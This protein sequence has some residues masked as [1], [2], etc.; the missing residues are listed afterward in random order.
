MGQGRPVTHARLRKG[1]TANVA[2]GGFV[3]PVAVLRLSDGGQRPEY[4]SRFGDEGA[5]RFAARAVPVSVAGVHDF[6]IGLPASRGGVV[7]DRAGR[8]VPVQKLADVA[9]G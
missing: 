3:Q 2:V 1:C 4:T 9:A 8:A 7:V 6:R 5:N